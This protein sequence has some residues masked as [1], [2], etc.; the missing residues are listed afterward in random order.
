[1]VPLL[2]VVPLIFMVNHFISISTKISISNNKPLDVIQIFAAKNKQFSEWRSQKK[3]IPL[4][5]SRETL[6]FGIS[7]R[8]DEC[9]RIDPSAAIGS[10]HLSKIDFS[11]P[12]NSYQLKTEEIYSSFQP[13]NHITKW[14]LK[15][16]TIAIETSGMDSQ[17]VTCQLDQ[18][19]IDRLNV[20]IWKIRTPVF[21]ILLF[22]W[23][24]DSVRSCTFRFIQFLISS[25]WFKKR[26]S[27]YTLIMTALGIILILNLILLIHSHYNVHPD[28]RM[29]NLA[30][31]YYKK[32]WLPPDL[33]D[34]AVHVLYL[35]SGWGVSYLS[36]L[37]LSYLF[38]AKFSNI[39]GSLIQDEYL[40]LR[41][42]N[43]LLLI[44]VIISVNLCRQQNLLAIL[45][46]SPQIWYL[47]SYFNGDAFPLGLS[48]IASA[49]LLN[50][51]SREFLSTTGVVGQVRIASSV[52]G[53][54]IVIG[55][56]VLA[57]RNY[58]LFLVFL[59]VYCLWRIYYTPSIERKRLIL[60]LTSSAV[61]GL[62]I[63]LAWNY[64]DVSINGT[65]KKVK[66]DKLAEKF[67]LPQ[68]KP[69]QQSSNQSADNFHLRDKGMK[70]KEIL[71]DH[72]WYKSTFK[73]FW[74][75]YGYMSVSAPAPY[76]LLI[77]FFIISFVGL[78]CFQFI[79]SMN[80][81]DRVLLLLLAGFIFI[82]ILT[83]IFHSWTYDYQ[84]QGRYLF[85]II[86]M[87]VISCKNFTEYI[88]R[89]VLI[90]LVFILFSLSIYAYTSIGIPRMI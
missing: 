33:D 41:F 45:L 1:M 15:G 40:R 47:F 38:A 53:L 52:L 11:S 84:P 66:I 67:A 85:P 54:G 51:L 73:S 26:I 87:I 86:G 6:N 8:P 32:N 48:I 90:A 28:E 30:A 24:V 39:V 34:P 82:T 79:G 74:G 27:S 72:Q 58:L 13:T 3:Y 9:L 10:V 80:S 46:I 23:L 68:Y 62:S 78:L 16:N 12:F 44:L 83:S 20:D 81:S 50:I 25:S 21:L 89:N 36:H 2:W 76:Y 19:Q 69:S 4:G 31:S 64:L 65:H 77:L 75:T 71:L 5:K 49:L 63:F 59:I 22:F 60:I 7:I 14:S 55:L 70:F 56:L 42:F 18:S 29:H 61:I 43:L 17:L 35:K 88:S 57:K 37:D